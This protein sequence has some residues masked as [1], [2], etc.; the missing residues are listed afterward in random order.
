MLPIGPGAAQAIE[1][2][3]LL[4]RYIVGQKRRGLSEK[5]TTLAALGRVIHQPHSLG[6][7]YQA[8]CDSGPVRS[9]RAWISFLRGA[10]TVQTLNLVLHPFVHL[11][12][13]A[14]GFAGLAVASCFVHIQLRDVRLSGSAAFLRQRYKRFNLVAAEVLV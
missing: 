13:L 3:D 12:L 4:R 7:G 10:D 2:C 11:H 8:S 9:L 1:D 5:R 14:A 6:F